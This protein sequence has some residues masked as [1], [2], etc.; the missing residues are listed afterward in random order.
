MR[1]PV[2]LQSIADRVGVSRMTVS[3]AFSRPEKLSAELRQRILAVAEE[4]GYVGPDPS[5]RA[6]ARGRTGTVGLLLTDRLGE[7]FRD[8]TATGFLAAVADELSARSL[9]MTL[10]TAGGEGDLV[11]ARDVP[12]DGA[13]VY[14]CQ[15]DS[16][17]VAWLVKRGLPL[18]TVDQETMAG[19]PSV[20]V[21]D[22]A[23]ARA[24]AQHLVDLGHQ[25]VGIVNLQ[26]D[27]APA[28]DP[29]HLEAVSNPPAAER[30]RGWR[31]A[32]VAAGVEPVTALA[33][34]RPDGAA[35]QAALGLLDR[36]DRPTGLVCFSDGFAVQ[37]I[38][39]GESLGLR[40][41]EDLS[42]VGFDDSP[43]ATSMRP[44]LTTVRQ[45]IAEKGRLA[46][47]ALLSLMAEEAPS[48][49]RVVLPTELVVRDSTAPAPAR[50]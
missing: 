6:L 13:L 39:A 22:R 12:V 15:K 27:A 34:F 7:A 25:R 42:V 37:A 48:E 20:N 14:V 8:V 2:T 16:P 31:D 10:I 18:V 17:D 43:L 21:D 1:T 28:A 24:A 29:E 32:L 30:N 33:A 23:G 36:P 3:N 5:A 38:R 45:P 50:A 9:S 44:A 19:T 4:L 40:V 11:P 26:P 49:D 47:R 35:Y 46:V 41:P